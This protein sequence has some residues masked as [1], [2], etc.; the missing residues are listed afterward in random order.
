MGADLNVSLFSIGSITKCWLLNL[1]VFGLH[2]HKL[3]YN[4]NIYIGS[5]RLDNNIVG[6]TVAAETLK[7][8]Q[9]TIVAL[10]WTRCKT[11]VHTPNIL[12]FYIVATSTLSWSKTIT[13]VW[14]STA[15]FLFWV[16]ADVI[17]ILPVGY[18]C[19]N[20]SRSNS[21]PFTI[22]LI[23]FEINTF[24]LNYSRWFAILVF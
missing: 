12:I 9:F 7:E 22:L 24:G 23:F 8:W 4:C 13:Q 15:R 20:K 14:R 11:A 2:I 3:I 17:L 6:V 1:Q 19:S 10:A 16:P 21:F 18:I 5:F